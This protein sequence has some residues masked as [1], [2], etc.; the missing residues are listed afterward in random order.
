VP[1]WHLTGAVL[2]GILGRRHDIK[3]TCVRSFAVE[4]TVPGY[5][6]ARANLRDRGLRLDQTLARPLTAAAVAAGGR[7]L[8]RLP[9]EEQQH[10]EIDKWL[11]RDLDREVEPIA[12]HGVFL[13][14]PRLLVY[15]PYWVAQMMTDKGQEWILFDAGFLTIAGYPSELEVRELLRLRDEDPLGAERESFRRVRIVPSRCPDCG[16]EESYDRRAVLIVCPNCHRAL[17]LGPEGAQIV[18][19]VH[20]VRGQAQLDAAYLPFWRYTFATELPDKKT[21]ASL[22]DYA[23]ALFPQPPPGFRP[24]GRHL[25]VPAFRLLGTEPGDEVFKDLCEWIHEQPPEQ[26]EG[27]IPLGGRPRLLGVSLSEREARR[28]APFVL[29]ALHNK[30]SAARMN[31]LLLKKAVKDARLSLGEPALVMVPFGRDGE[32]VTIPERKLRIPA[33][34]LNRGPE[35]LQMRATVVAAQAQSD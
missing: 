35:L 28:L 22:D 17:Q 32:D 31:T 30:A 21:L 1:Y 24:T 13:P 27:K 3:T 10:R 5:D 20:A 23:K 15:R 16:F 8:P 26:R 19:Y 14:G 25:F 12:K 9:L 18:P 4:H 29:V 33:L 7:F 11:Q 34:L 2:Q 6:P